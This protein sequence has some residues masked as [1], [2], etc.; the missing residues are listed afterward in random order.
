[1]GE[2]PNSENRGRSG[3]GPEHQ[4]LANRGSEH[5]IGGLSMWQLWQKLPAFFV[6]FGLKVMFSCF[7]GAEV[8]DLFATFLR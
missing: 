2:K 7:F 5:T 4:F 3:V 1:M 6:H 8:F